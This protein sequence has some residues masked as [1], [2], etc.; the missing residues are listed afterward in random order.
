M[1]TEASQYRVFVEPLAGSLGGGFAAYAPDVENAEY[2][3]TPVPTA[4][5]TEEAT[6]EVTTAP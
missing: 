4:E 6:A 2:A 3:I 5:L 1:T